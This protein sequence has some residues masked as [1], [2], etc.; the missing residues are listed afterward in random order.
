MQRMAE[1]GLLNVDGG[2]EKNQIRKKVAEMKRT[3]EKIEINSKS[4]SILKEKGSWPD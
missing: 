2:G 3:L 4:K 1:T